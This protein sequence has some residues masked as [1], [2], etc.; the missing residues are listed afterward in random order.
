VIDRLS[1][2]IAALMT[3]VAL[4][5]ENST[6]T[7]A[8]ISAY[9][10]ISA[11]EALCTV[12]MENEGVVPGELLGSNLTQLNK[13]SPA[14]VDAFYDY[15]QQTCPRLAALF[16]WGSARTYLGSDSFQNLPLEKMSNG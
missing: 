12:Y 4:P 1:I 11:A 8:W 13:A 3:R 15:L 16:V 2:R 5:P 10:A 6:A 9:E 7:N 14:A